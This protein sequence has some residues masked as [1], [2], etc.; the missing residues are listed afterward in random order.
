MGKKK[1]LI[2]VFADQWRYHAMGCTGEDHVNTPAMDAFASDSVFCDNAVSTYPLCSPHRAALLTGKNPLSLGMWTNCKIG[3]NENVMLYPQEKTISD[4]LHEE[5]YLTG[6][7]GKW[8]LDASEMNFSP[9]PES[10]ARE[11]DA[12]TPPG[13]RR[14]NFDYWYSYGAMNRHMHPHYWHDS[15]RMINISQWSAEHDTDIFISYLE[16][17]KNEDRPVLAFLSW[18]PPHPPYTDIDDRRKALYTED[19]AFRPNVPEEWRSDSDY[20]EKRH[21]YFAAVA[22]LDEQFG[23]LI[24]Y[25]KESGMY[26]DSVIVLS[27]DH[28][29]MMGS[30]GL[31]GKNVWYEESLR[32]PLVIHDPDLGSGCS[33]SCIMS[34]DQMPTL[35]DLMGVKIPSIVNGISHASSL[36]SQENG[37]AYSYHMMIPGM[38]EQVTPYRERG[39]DN[40]CFGWRCIRTDREKYVVDNGI[41]PGAE[42]KRFLYDLGK[43]PYEMNPLELSSTDV[44]AQHFDSL[45][46]DNKSLHNDIFLI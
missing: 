33:H 13:E 21:D 2:Y 9:S 29:D 8:H 35:L 42:V 12:Y 27:G 24:S 46:K 36:L 40:R 34:E 19:Y 15:S 7:V 23:R 14:H 39:L 16:S 43:D 26:D 45:I 18:N 4:I 17:V 32:I 41:V 37:R 20:L 10:G 6:Y 3:L 1:N 30:Q 28:G 11:W 44:Q 5:G 38:P 31:Y 25:L 22:G